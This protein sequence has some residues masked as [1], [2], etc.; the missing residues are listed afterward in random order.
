MIFSKTISYLVT[1]M[2]VDQI[3]E[4]YIDLTIVKIS[5]LTHIDYYITSNMRIQCFYDFIDLCTDHLRGIL[6]QR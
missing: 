6:L 4:K 2:P 5:M 1:E 3:Q